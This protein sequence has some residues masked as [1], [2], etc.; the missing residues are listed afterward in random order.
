MDLGAMAS[1]RPGQRRA[2]TR[3]GLRPPDQVGQW[4]DLWPSREQVLR[5]NAAGE[6][7]RIFRGCAG[8]ARR[9]VRLRPVADL[10]GRNGSARTEGGMIDKP[11]LFSGPMVRA[12]LA[13]TKTQT[14]RALNP[15]PIQN[16]AGLW[17]WSRKGVSVQGAA[18]ELAL[19]QRIAVGDRLYVRESY[20]QLGHWEP[21]LGHVTKGGR[22][23][24]AFVS[25]DSRIV[26]AEPANTRLGRHHL[27]P[28]TSAWHKRLGRFMPRA[29]SR[30]TLTVTD[31]RVER[32][33]DISR[34]DAMAEGIVQTW[35]DFMGDPPEWA[36]AS[37]NRHGDAS[38]S[39]IYDNRTSAENYRELWNN[40][41]GA[42]S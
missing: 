41:N 16:A 26:F 15:Q 36:V 34:D 13:G 4:A 24:W 31:V 22:Q 17:T 19:A 10:P 29:A 8:Q 32:L 21:V 20:Y 6:V 11:I 18:L 23:K 40:I 25:D 39:H 3:D 42:G 12:L 28:G 35:G 30:I 14:R 38:G 37:I 9:V 1:C 33:Q 7:Q 5:G 27:D 2:A